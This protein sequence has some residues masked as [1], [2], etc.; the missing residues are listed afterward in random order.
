[1]MTPHTPHIPGSTSLVTHWLASVQLKQTPSGRVITNVRWVDRPTTRQ[2]LPYLF[3]T[4]P[5]DAGIV[6]S[7]EPPEYLG[8]GYT[9][10]EAWF[11]LTAPCVVFLWIYDPSTNRWR[12]EAIVVVNP[13]ER[14]RIQQGLYQPQP[15][16]MR[17][18]SGLIH[19]PKRDQQRAGQPEGGDQDG[20]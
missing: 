4:D 11:R 17:T 19:R 7:G 13:D 15:E 1:M 14:R 3:R 18:L 6:A 2:C 10:G 16:L 20:H 8:P 12:S 9:A 5:F